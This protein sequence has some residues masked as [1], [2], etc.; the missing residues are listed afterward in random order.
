MDFGMPTLIECDGLRE[1]AEL[2]MA[3][4]LDFVELNMNLPEYRPR[5]LENNA[6]L[7]KYASSAPVYFTVHLDENLNVADFN[8]AISDAYLDTV[9]RT[10]R[11]CAEICAPVLNMHMN[12]GV[13]FTLPDRKVYLF[14]KYRDAYMRAY[15]KFG[16]VCESEIGDADIRICI[17]NTDGWRDFEKGAIEHLLESRVF[18]L[19]FDIGHSHSVGDADEGFISEHA[20]KLRHFHIHDAR[21]KSNHLALGTGEIDLMS[22]LDL[23][24]AHGC[25]CVAETKTVSALKTS[26]EWLRAHG[27]L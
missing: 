14:E 12:R 7:R 21:G 4:G 18:A 20:D 5:M 16:S 19:T 2:C 15:E 8:D 26:V 22:R 23:A 13:H 3:L 11:V 25:R 24:K 17:E 6:E 1:N 27:R 9:K 10:I